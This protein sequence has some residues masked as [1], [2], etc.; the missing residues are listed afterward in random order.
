MTNNQ[1]NVIVLELSPYFYIEHSEAHTIESISNPEK[2]K[3]LLIDVQIK[4]QA[5]NTRDNPRAIIGGN[6]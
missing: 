3:A 5:K 6:L 2:I 1:N 4:K